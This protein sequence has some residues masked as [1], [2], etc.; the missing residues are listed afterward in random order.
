MP[1]HGS[2]TKAGKVRAQTPK[3]DGRPRR[4]P[5]PRRRNWLNFQKRIVHAPVEQRRFRR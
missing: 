3:I 1:T 5:T 2:L 4:S